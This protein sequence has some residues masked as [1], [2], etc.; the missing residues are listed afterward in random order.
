MGGSLLTR[1]RAIG[2]EAFSPSHISLVLLN[3]LI[4]PFWVEATIGSYLRVEDVPDSRFHP[5]KADIILKRV[6]LFGGNGMTPL[7][8]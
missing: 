7:L 8:G 6:S 4:H 1:V 2:L 5:I 3:R